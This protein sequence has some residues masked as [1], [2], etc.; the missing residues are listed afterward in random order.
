MLFIIKNNINN[1]PLMVGTS[2]NKYDMRLHIFE[3]T[4]RGSIPDTDSCK[5]DNESLSQTAFDC[6]EDDDGNL[7]PDTKL[8]IVY[9]TTSVQGMGAGSRTRSQLSQSRIDT[10]SH[11]PIELTRAKP[12]SE[13]AYYT[14]E[15]L[16]KELLN[17]ISTIEQMEMARSGLERLSFDIICSGNK[18][19]IKQGETSFLGEINGS[20]RVETRHKA[21]YER[22]GIQE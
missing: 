9:E 18:R 19:N 6:V 20:R 8:E 17:S 7:D 13:N 15:P 12:S 11:V 4:G 14:L 10:E 21:L 1:T 16:F 5:S 2:I 3:L 22:Q